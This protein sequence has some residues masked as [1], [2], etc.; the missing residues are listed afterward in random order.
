MSVGGPSTGHWPAYL[1]TGGRLDGR[2]TTLYALV[3]DAD[4]YY[5]GIPVP[6]L[7]LT[8][9]DVPDTSHLHR[10]RRYPGA[11]DIEPVAAIEAALDARALLARDPNSAT[12]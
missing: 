4:E 10:S 6:E 11:L 2:S 7:P 5:D 9:V 3:V 1:A 8:E 12:G